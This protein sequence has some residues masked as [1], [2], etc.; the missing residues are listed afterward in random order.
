MYEVPA[1]DCEG[2]EMKVD[3]QPLK[4]TLAF[5]GQDVEHFK[6]VLMF[7]LRVRDREDRPGWS[8]SEWARKTL[9]EIIRLEGA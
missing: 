2:E 4:L 6:D 9:N 1:A 3:F 7:A 8:V 5:E